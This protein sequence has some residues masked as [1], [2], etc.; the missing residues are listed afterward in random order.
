MCRKDSPGYNLTQINHAQ[1][2]H[3]TQSGS[4]CKT[5]YF[6]KWDSRKG[7]R[8]MVTEGQRKRPLSA[9]AVLCLHMGAGSMSVSTQVLWKVRV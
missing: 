2:V 5:N 6:K 4:T 9:G 1:Q 3:H 8:A 7:F